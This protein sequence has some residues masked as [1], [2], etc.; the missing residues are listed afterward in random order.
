[1]CPESAAFLINLSAQ[2]A[3]TF[4]NAA[5]PEL[6]GVA[7]GVPMGGA[8]RVHDI[9]LD[10]VGGSD[11][12]LER[13][14]VFEANAELN[15]DNLY[16]VAPPKDTYF[17][18]R[19]DALPDSIV[20]LAVPEYGT[21]SGVITDATGVWLLAGKSG[22]SAPGLSNRNLDLKTELAGMPFECGAEGA[23]FAPADLIPENGGTGA[24][25]APL[26]TNVTHTA[27]VA[28]ETDYEYYAKFG[29]ETAANQICIACRWQ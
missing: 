27:R 22:Y 19:I 26:C 10:Q 8:L 16:S 24:D 20:V 23:A 9:D 4:V 28:V 25:T 29:N 14:R 18:G 1:M 5:N 21:V 3:P 15:V 6:P 12:T 17:R 7:R 2:A 13:F 11:L